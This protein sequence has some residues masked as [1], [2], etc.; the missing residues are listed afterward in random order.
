MSMEHRWDDTD[1]RQLKYLGKN[2]FQYQFVYYKYYM[3]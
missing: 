1:M 2:L 3:D